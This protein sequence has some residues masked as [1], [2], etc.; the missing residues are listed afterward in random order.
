MAEEEKVAEIAKL[1][2]G[3]DDDGIDDEIQ[4]LER[5]MA[6]MD[7]ETRKVSC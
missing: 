1:E 6:M 4:A 3:A 7:A 2:E 5:D